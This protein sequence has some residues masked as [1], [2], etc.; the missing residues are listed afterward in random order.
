MNS[1]SQL[2]APIE[3]ESLRD[4]VHSFLTVVGKC[5]SDSSPATGNQGLVYSREDIV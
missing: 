1:C 5:D 3:K 2:V 4:F